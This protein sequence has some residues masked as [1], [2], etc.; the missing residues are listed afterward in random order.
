MNSYLQYIRS[1]LLRNYFDVRILGHPRSTNAQQ[2][3]RLE[4]GFGLI[5][6]PREPERIEVRDLNKALPHELPLYPLT[7]DEPHR[8]RF[9]IDEVLSVEAECEHSAIQVRKEH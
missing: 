5:R 7:V 2:L 4:R 9:G 1:G 3:L 6:A 8:S